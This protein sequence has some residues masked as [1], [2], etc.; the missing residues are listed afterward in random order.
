MK[1]VANTYKNFHIYYQLWTKVTVK[2]L[3]TFIDAHVVD[4]Y[5]FE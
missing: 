5:M 2:N 4:E 3:F 1:E